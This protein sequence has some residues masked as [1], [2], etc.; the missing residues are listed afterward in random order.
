MFY[1]PLVQTQSL[2]Q[3]PTIR[4]PRNQFTENYM[5]STLRAQNLGVANPL[6]GSTDSEIVSDRPSSTVNSGVYVIPCYDCE[7]SYVGQTGKDL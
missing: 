5:A 6:Y 7:L 4:L 2:S 1:S 3:K